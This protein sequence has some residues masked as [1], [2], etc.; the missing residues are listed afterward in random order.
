MRNCDW[1]ASKNISKPFSSQS[2][3][4]FPC[5]ITKPTPPKYI[6]HIF[7]MKRTVYQTVYFIFLIEMKKWVTF[8]NITRKSVD[9]E[10]SHIPALIKANRIEAS[11][12]LAYVAKYV[13]QFLN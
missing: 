3:I 9:G 13:Y 11:Y 8:E 2:R 10:P 7:N 6:S 5:C 12:F 1:P 4:K